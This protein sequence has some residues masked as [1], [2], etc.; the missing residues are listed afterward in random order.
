[1][2][3]NDRPSITIEHDEPLVISSTGPHLHDRH[4][5]TMSTRQLWL[6]IEAVDHLR[7]AGLAY[8]EGSGTIPD[9][10]SELRDQLRTYW[11]AIMR[12]GATHGRAQAPALR[13][14]NRDVFHRANQPVK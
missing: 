2:P 6:F 8:P 7:F 4:S 11:E 10:L 9:Q 3:R 13:L 12:Q 5:V 1:M 14:S